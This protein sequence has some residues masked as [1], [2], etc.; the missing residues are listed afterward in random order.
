[1]IDTFIETYNGG[2]FDYLFPE[3][4]KI[5]IEDIARGLSKVCRFG[6]QI[7]SFYSVAQHCTI[8]SYQV[9]PQ[10]ALEALLHDASEAFMCDVPKPLKTMLPDYCVIEKRVEKFLCKKF[11][12][13][14]PMSKEIKVADLRMLATE[15]EWLLPNSNLCWKILDGVLPYGIVIDPEEHSLAMEKF[16]N[17]YNELTLVAN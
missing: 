11:G 17:R 16:I 8:M 6:G 1:M 9:E 12:V 7:A 13:P 5:T 10:F 4:S 15:K 14:F 2:T 3:D